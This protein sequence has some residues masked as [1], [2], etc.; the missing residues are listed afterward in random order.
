MAAKIASY[1]PAPNTAGA[2]FTGSNNYVRTDAN[3]IQKNTYS[4]RLDQDFT[5]NTRMLARFSYDDTPWTRA[6]P[7]GPGDEGSA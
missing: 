4:A 2:A 6:S 1:W 5:S 7:Y 3:N